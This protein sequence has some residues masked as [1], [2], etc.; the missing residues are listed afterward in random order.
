[1]GPDH[2]SICN[3]DQTNDNLAIPANVMS[4][5][6]V[7]G[8][9]RKFTYLQT[10]RVRVV[11]PS[12]LSKLTRCVLDSGSQ[13]S[14]IS[15]SIIDVLQLEVIDQRELTVGAIESA[16]ITSSSRG[17]VRLDLRGVCTKSSTT[18]TSFESAYKFLP[19]PALPHDVNG[20]T[21]ILKL[22]FADPRDSE[23]LPI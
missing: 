15:T 12:G 10:V 11:G 8:A 1:M 2:K 21:H 16:C 18:I 3:V 20:M 13:T 7:D 23:D 4:V 17:L 9:L 5:S 14:F 19:Q 22:Q 6:K